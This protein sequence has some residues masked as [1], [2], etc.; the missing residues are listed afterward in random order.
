MIG[1]FQK[2][3]L[4]LNKEY[5]KLVEMR[6]DHMVNPEDFRHQREVTKLTMLSTAKMLER[7]MYVSLVCFGF[8][9]KSL[10][11]VVYAHKT[12]TEYKL[13]IEDLFD[14]FICS[15]IGYWIFIYI[16]YS[17]HE[18]TNTKIANTKQEIFMYDILVAR[19]TGVFHF[20]VLVAV[21]ASTFW[22]RMFLMLKLTKTFGP[23]IKIIYA[24]MREL[25]IFLVL[26]GIQ[27]FIF[28]CVGVLI[29]SGIP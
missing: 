1:D 25:M 11:T 24:M 4:E 7:S 17:N 21:V 16:T 12:Q 14:L 5:D 13:K 29:F 27:L 18:A 28:T 3:F 26:W 20:E 23:L 22:L 15:L 9:I 6:T 8:P 2:G 10:M 19:K